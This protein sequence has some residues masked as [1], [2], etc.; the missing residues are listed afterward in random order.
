MDSLVYLSLFIAAIT[1]GAVGYFLYGWSQA[2]LFAE[3]E[4]DENDLPS[5][6]KSLPP[7][8]Y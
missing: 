6:P 3:G 2:Q 1:I 8:I 5:D 7:A 4:S